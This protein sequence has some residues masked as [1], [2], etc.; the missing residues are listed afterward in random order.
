[1]TLAAL[2]PGVGTSTNGKVGVVCTGVGK[3]VAAG[4][5]PG[6][7]GRDTP[8][9]KGDGLGFLIEL[10]LVGLA[11]S[12]L[13]C[14]ANNWVVLFGAAIQPLPHPHNKNTITLRIG[15]FLIDKS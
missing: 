9:K 13:D 2:N 6:N 12:V 3:L 15:E 7:I 1:M 8:G 4:V 10:G 5:V 11:F 14:L